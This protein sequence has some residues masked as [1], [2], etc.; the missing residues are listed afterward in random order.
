MKVIKCDL[1]HFQAN[2]LSQ[3]K[4]H[5]A[6]IHSDLRPWKCTHLGCSCK[7]KLKGNLQRHLRVHVSDPVLRKPFACTIQDCD[8]RTSYKYKL[9][10]HV[11]HRHTP[12]RSRDF[13]CTL[14]PSRFYSKC[15]LTAHIRN[16]VR[17]KVFE[18][19]ICKYP[20]KLPSCRSRS[21]CAREK[22]GRLFICW[23]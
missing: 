9:N 17:E 1:C 12:G 8:Y 19:N 3:V 6:S 22:N 11:Q 21:K 5:M 2:K 18:C 14:C 20:Q 23:M 7:F 4:S 15:A 10:S 16:H 13:P